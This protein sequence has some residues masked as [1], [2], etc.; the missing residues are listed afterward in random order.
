[1]RTQKINFH[2]GAT[3]HAQF[4]SLLRILGGTEEAIVTLPPWP[5]GEALSTA[6]TCTH[7]RLEV[8]L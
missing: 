8:G 5:T 2:L 1:M 3:A 7:G 4:E 6:T